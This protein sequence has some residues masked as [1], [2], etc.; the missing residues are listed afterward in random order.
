[1]KILAFDIGGTL[2]K[3]AIYDEETGLSCFEEHSYPIPGKDGVLKVLRSCMDKSDFDGIGISTAGLVDEKKGQI[4]FCS[5]AIPGYTG[6]RLKEIFE[7]EY[8]KPVWLVN[9]VNAAALGEAYFGA[10]K[11]YD[12][13][14][15]LTYGTGVGGAIVINKEIYG[16]KSGYAGEMGHIVTHLHGKDCVCGKKGCYNEYAS[17][18]ALTE[19]CMMLDSSFDNGKKI[20]A[21]LNEG[22]S[23]VK[24]EVDEWIDEIIY[25]LINIVHI[26]N[27]PCLVLGGGIMDQ[28]YIVSEVN[29]KLKTAVMQGY[30]DLEILKAFLGNKAGLMGAAQ[31]TL[32]KMK[33]EKSET[34]N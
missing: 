27:P 32:R 23:Q 22:N 5:D 30:S 17:T 31:H 4:I 9:D 13:F 24:K 14:I 7:G 21:A 2:I 11:D 15:C 1:M 3:S 28:E 34:N 18:R 20:F 10:G 25:G 12:D 26:F 29:K 16:G 19:R 6:T 33:F 8:N